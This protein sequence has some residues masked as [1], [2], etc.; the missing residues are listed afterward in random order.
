[1]EHF[2]IQF[3]PDHRTVRIHAGATL[4]EAAGQADIVLV[5]PC[6]GKGTCRKCKVRIEPSGEEV[7]ACQFK[8]TQDLTVTIPHA[9]RYYRQQ[10][11]IHGREKKITADP[12]WKKIHIPE[13]PATKEQLQ[14]ILSDAAGEAVVIPAAFSFHADGQTTAVLRFDGYN[15]LTTPGGTAKRSSP[16]ANKLDRGL[17]GHWQLVSLEKT[18]HRHLYGAAVDIGTTTVVLHLADLQTGK[19][20]AT[21]STAN[22]QHQHGDDVISR[23]HFASELAGQDWMQ[24]ATIDCLN[25][26]LHR[27][28]DEAKV[29]TEQVYELVAVGNTAMNHLLMKFPVAQLGQSPYAPHT[30]D[31]FDTPAESLGLALNPHGNLHTVQN[32]AGFVGSDTLAGAVAADMAT[33]KQTT[34][35]VDIGTNGEIVLCHEGKLYAASCAAGPALEGARISHG[36]RA[37]DGAIQ[38]V[39]IDAGD[40]DIDLDVIGD[41]TPLSICGSG[42]IDALAVLV[43]TG[44]ID[45]SGGFVEKATLTGKLA[46]A[47]FNRLTEYEKQPAFV[48]ADGQSPILLTQRDIRQLQLA[49]AA[50][51]A[52]IKI[53]K[54][55]AGIDNSR[56]EKLLLAG[57]FGN[58][59]QKASALRIGLLP[60][61]S[62]ERIH[63]IGN[64]AGGGALEILLNRAIRANCQALAGRVEYIELASRPDFQDIFTNCLMF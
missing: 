24:R 9:S 40:G 21:A 63:F 18:N 34:L 23:I 14:K 6:G 49:K 48:L 39:V 4:F 45:S 8:I 57:A 19:I 26:L 62:Q 43:E 36:S 37:M 61:V 17:T 64:A 2:T 3:L 28:A 35:L 58:Y 29:C 12:C 30:T 38:R 27:V 32:I 1:M 13:L 60:H 11:L 52:G 33:E 15:N 41:G 22:P 53:L 16:E 47:M 25:S 54:K 20:L 56:I 5:S 55:S 50:I 42:L 59:I 51:R 46:P 10:I 44:I 7:L 31:A